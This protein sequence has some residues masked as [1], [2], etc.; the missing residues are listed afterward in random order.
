MRFGKPKEHGEAMRSN[1]HH[2]VHE[3]AG[4]FLFALAFFIFFSLISYRV[5]DSSFNTFGTT[6]QVNNW[7]GSFGSQIAE[8][9]FTLFGGASFGLPLFLFGV[10][11]RGRKSAEE[12]HALSQGLGGFF[13]L[14]SNCGL[15]SLMR[16]G[17]GLAGPKVS[18]FISGGLIG[19]ILISS[20]LID[21]FN[22]FG[23]A[24]ILVTLLLV[25]LILFTQTSLSQGIVLGRKFFKKV[26]LVVKRM[27]GWRIFQGWVGRE[28][29]PETE[30][31]E[32]DRLDKKSSSQKKKGKRGLKENEP[33]IE[34]CF[35]GQQGLLPPSALLDP[36]EKGRV[37]ESDQSAQI[38]SKK[39]EEK[40]LNFGV[41]G[42]IVQ[43]LP[44][45]V[46]TR[47]EFEPAPGIKIAKIANLSDDVA[48]AMKALSVRIVAP[49]PGKSVVGLEIPNQNR[50]K[51]FLREILEADQFASAHSKLALAL[52]KDIAGIPYVTNLAKMPHLLV[53][54]ATGSG[55]SVSVNAFICSILFNATAEEVKFIM[56][57]PKMLEL[58]IYN[59][60][61]HLLAPV[62]VDPKEAANALRW[63]TREMETR[64]RTLAEKGVRN[65]DQYNQMIISE[66]N[67]QPSVGLAGETKVGPLP[68]IVI[69][70][71][72]F[73][74]LML[75]SG[76]EVETLLIRLAQMARAVGIHLIIATQRPSVDVVTGLIKANFPCRVAFRVSSKTDSRTILDANGAERLLGYG[77]MLFLPPNSS[78]IIRLH[79]SF[80][81]EIEIK[82]L[83][84]YLAHQGRPEYNDSILT[85]TPEEDKLGKGQSEEEYD[86]LYDKAVDLVIK[87]RQA[88]ISMIQRRLR[89]GYNR[90][91]RMIEIMERDGVVSK[92]Q[93]SKPREVLVESSYEE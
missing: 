31:D 25:S 2:L 7:M 51:V 1:K 48:L 57:D 62:V 21:Y 14:V 68:Y 93:G 79:G 77:D 87:T 59:D 74:D 45:P 24:L 92:P 61:P 20:F 76:R 39:L 19:E 28:S 85:F 8:L 89:I 56:I 78:E 81:T 63:A 15:L 41:E 37:G 49:V 6:R 23:T 66:G 55:K 71:D 32:P 22:L 12:A 26:A 44:G 30:P 29:W 38:V 84:K 91:A 4:V 65:I 47:Y 52:G 35:E 9:L 34:L 83:V 58:G 27:R 42:K 18:L 70:I 46:V 82:R 50:E 11:W 67:D 10:A 43:V 80:I 73:A 86:D 17:L 13:F 75:T 36:P 64:Y 90:A 69:V 60:I 16:H 5:S 40:L 33:E 53:A 88:S 54:G 3:I 72:E